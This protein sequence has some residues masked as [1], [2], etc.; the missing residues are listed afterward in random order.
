MSRPA[1]HG[2]A[3]LAATA[4]LATLTVLATGLAYTTVVDQHLARNAL[5][6]L[7][8][9]ALARSGVAAAAVVVREAGMAEAADTLR[10][11][12]ARNSGR[13]PLGAG[14]VRVQVTDEARRLDLNA[15]ELAGAL[16]RLL[17]IL[18]LDPGLADT[19]ADWTDADDLP[20]AAGAE[21]GWYLRLLPPY[22]PANGPLRSLGDLRLV[23]GVDEATL[24]RL[25]PYVTTA[26][27]RAVNPNTAPREVLLAL[28][29]EAVV[30][31]LLAARAERPIDPGRDLPALLP[32][33]GSAA[34]A[35]LARR[36]TARGNHY[37]VRALGG[38]GDVRRAV[39]ATLWAPVGVDPEVVGWRPFVPDVSPSPGEEHT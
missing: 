6:A 12:W 17:R 28:A 1:E 4:A 20:R 29:D 2:V 10:S 22:I 39:E 21:R 38:V 25:R 24:A 9:D 37:A 35:T 7:Q 3:L 16:P 5:A 15:P 8:A 14:W 19:I 34:R 30:E 23:R 36:L 18:D 11:A 13:Q 27:E 32:D 31:R 26:G 33:L